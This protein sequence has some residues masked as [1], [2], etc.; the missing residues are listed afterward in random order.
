M[1]AAAARDG[2]KR[3]MK[4]LEQLADDELGQLA[5]ELREE[6]LKRQGSAQHCV[7]CASEFL[8]RRGSRYCSGRCRTAAYRLRTRRT[9]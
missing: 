9:A 5:A 3:H 2:Y 7:V 4:E 1:K 6:M 8:G